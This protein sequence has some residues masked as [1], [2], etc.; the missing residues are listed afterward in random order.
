MQVQP[1]RH[2][3]LNIIQNA[4]P[5]QTKFKNNLSRCKNSFARDVKIVHDD[6]KI[7]HYDVKIVY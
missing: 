1:I 4:E 6:V 3:V 5:Y 7:V 2:D